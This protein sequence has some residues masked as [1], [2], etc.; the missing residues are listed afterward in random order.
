MENLFLFNI[1]YYYLFL[2]TTF[3]QREKGQRK[4]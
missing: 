1:I 2:E 4:Y 3:A